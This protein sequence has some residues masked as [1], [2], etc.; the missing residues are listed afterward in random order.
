MRMKGPIVAAAVAA[1]VLSFAA[2]A[3]SATRWRLLHADIVRSSHPLATFTMPMNNPGVVAERLVGPKGVL[4]L[5]IWNVSCTRG[6]TTAYSK[7]TFTGRGLVLHVLRLPFRHPDT[8]T[9]SVS[10]GLKHPRY[11]AG[12]P[13]VTM[14][15][16]LLQRT[17]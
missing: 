15:T 10:G 3:A 17:R 4:M 1:A 12:A 7:G 9:I 16:E 14:H 13:K 2:V 11:D 8:C 5:G 6:V